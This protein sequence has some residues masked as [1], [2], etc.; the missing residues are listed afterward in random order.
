MAPFVLNSWKTKS[1]PFNNSLTKDFIPKF[2]VG[3]DQLEVVYKLKLVGLVLNSELTWD[4][5]IDYTVGRV[6]KVLWQLTRFR[7]HGADR[8]KLIQF[9]I[10]KILSILMFCAVCFHSSLTKEHSRQLELQQKR[11]LACLL[12]SDYQNYNNALSVTSLTRLDTLREEACLKWAIKAETNPQHSHLFPVNP[13]VIN[14]RF[15]K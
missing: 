13:S 11:S 15:R 5:H 8:K 4:S 12:G 3:Q 1:I 14:T 2:S 7:Q 10:L 9:Y 6:N